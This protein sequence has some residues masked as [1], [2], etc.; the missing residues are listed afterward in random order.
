MADKAENTI[1]LTNKITR[2]PQTEA[3]ANALQTQMY[4]GILTVRTFEYGSR[5]N[6]SLSTNTT[7]DADLKSNELFKTN[8]LC[9]KISLFLFLILSASYLFDKRYLKNVIFWS[10]FLS[11]KA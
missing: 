8:T 9:F 2:F 1:E 10:L 11:C 6:E 5:P 4:N 3:I 7:Y